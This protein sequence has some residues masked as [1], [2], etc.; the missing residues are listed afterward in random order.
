MTSGRK[1][2]G[3]WSRLR[4]Q[5]LRR[6]RFTCYKCGR[7]ADQVDHV[8]P[9]ALGGEDRHENLRA[10]CAHCHSV[11]S[12]AEYGEIRRRLRKQ[13][14]NIRRALDAGLCRDCGA[15]GERVVR[16]NPRGNDSSANMVTLC[17]RCASVRQYQRQA[18]R[19]SEPG[20]KA[21]MAEVA[22]IRQKAARTAR[23]STTHKA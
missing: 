15:R 12:R 1:V 7:Q 9:A 14:A 6:D 8:V 21:W 4:K 20:R 3:A 22:R 10:I 16:I 18:E 23:S 5:V 11:K 17:R 19:E 13:Q 2:S